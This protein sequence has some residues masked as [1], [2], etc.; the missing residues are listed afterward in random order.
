MGCHGEGGREGAIAGNALS[1]GIEHLIGGQMLYLF[2]GDHQTKREAAATAA[3]P[4]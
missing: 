4:V 1:T 2:R 3:R